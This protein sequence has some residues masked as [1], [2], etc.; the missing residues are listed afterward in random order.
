MSSA[1]V[2]NPNTRNNP[3]SSHFVF[4]FIVGS[5]AE[6][7]VSLD[8]RSHLL[9]YNFPASTSKPACDT[10]RSDSEG[11]P[12]KA[13]IRYPVF[14]LLIRPP[15]QPVSPVI[16]GRLAFPLSFKVSAISAALE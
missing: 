2:E 12:L 6:H 9:R 13:A 8:R 4:R 10:L 11:P 1:C 5:Q 14:P 16:G 3:A 7:P 15:C